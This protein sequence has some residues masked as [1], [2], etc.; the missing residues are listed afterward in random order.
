MQRKSFASAAAVSLFELFAEVVPWV[1][2]GICFTAACNVWAPTG[3][4]WDATGGDSVVKRGA[5]L[6][7]TVPVQL[8][9]HGPV[10]FAPFDATP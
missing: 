1:A 4:L 10:L 7:A 3:G 9:E 2:V 8:C 6:A 5:L